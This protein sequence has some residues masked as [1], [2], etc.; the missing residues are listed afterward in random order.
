[1]A[2]PV[3]SFE[4]DRFGSRNPVQNKQTIRGSEFKAQTDAV[5][6]SLKGDHG[7]TTTDTGRVPVNR[8]L[9][10]QIPG[11]TRSLISTH[12]ER[13]KRRDQV[14]IAT[15]RGLP[16]AGTKGLFPAGLVFF[17]SAE[18][19]VTSGD[20]VTSWASIGGG[21]TLTA[22][23]TPLTNQILTPSGLPAVTFASSGVGTDLLSASGLALFP[24]VTGATL[25]TV[26]NYNVRATSNMVARVVEVAGAATKFRT[27]VSELINLPGTPAINANDSNTD[28]ITTLAAAGEDTW[29]V[30]TYT[31]DY[32]GVGTIRVNGVQ[33]GRT[34]FARSGVSASDADTL[35]VGGIVSATI[36][37]NHDVHLADWLLWPSLLTNEWIASAEQF[38]GEKHGIL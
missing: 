36:L 19:L 26:L 7:A 29:F 3:A 11:R 25:V 4:N 37:N 16:K 30:V 15:R 8:S 1:M 10:I 9:G 13:V 12:K 2:D 24:G 35:T 27:S 33:A 28:A 20:D 38:L 34:T 17:D 14:A 21:I 23:G 22:T 32:K 5:E 18:N 31:V 6:D